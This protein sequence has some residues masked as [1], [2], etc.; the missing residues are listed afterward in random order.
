MRVTVKKQLMNNNKVKGII[1]APSTPRTTD[2]IYWGYQVRYADSFRKILHGNRPLLSIVVFILLVVVLQS[3]HF[4][5]AECPFGG[6]YDL[7]I[8]SSNNSLNFDGLNK[9]CYFK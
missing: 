5:R 9:Y 7:K 1:V 4:C 3:Q 6:G 8:A 2:G